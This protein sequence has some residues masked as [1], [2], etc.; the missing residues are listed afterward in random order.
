MTI[1][2]MSFNFVNVH[3]TPVSPAKAGR[4][5]AAA[6][7]RTER[8]PGADSDRGAERPN[9]LVQALGA[10]LREIGLGLGLGVGVG[11]T[12]G[13]SAN[14]GS[15]A[16]TDTPATPSTVSDID[17]A[18]QE[19][20][21]ALLGAL[22]AL[23]AGREARGPSREHRQDGEH[24]HHEQSHD[25]GLRSTGYGDLAQ[26]LERLSQTIVKMPPAA[27]ATSAPATA[28]SPVADTPSSVAPEVQSDVSTMAPTTSVRAEASPL[29]TAFSK[30]FDALQP[31]APAESPGTSMATRLQQFLHTASQALSRSGLD[32]AAAPQIGAFVDAS[33]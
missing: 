21:H 12:E 2:S 7:D 1:S 33:A 28:V 14:T 18:V 11:A 19:F 17:T 6:T 15:T 25:H 31:N 32:V 26:R 24:R 10:A 16:T 20:A 3:T 5:P 22:G 8:A 27:P 9:R 13:M 4:T 29:I 30:L 23:G